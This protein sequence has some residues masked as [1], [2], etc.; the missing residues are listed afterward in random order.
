[1]LTAVVCGAVFASPSAEAV[2]A[3]IRATARPGGPGVLLIVKNYTGDRLNFGVAAEQARS[4]GIDV[5]M[6]VV[7]DDCA[8]PKAKGITGGRGI[9]GTVLV[10]K[11]AG[12]AAAEGA[13]LAEVTATAQATADS[14]RTLG[15]SLSGC[16]LPGQPKAATLGENE[17]ELGLGIHGEPGFVKANVTPA[18]SLVDRVLA[19]ITEPS[20]RTH[21]SLPLRKG[22]KVVLLV[23]NLGS[24]THLELAVVAGR[25]K[26]VL[27]E[28]GVE[29]V[30]V[31]Q[32]P[33]MT[34]LDMHGFSV[35]L[36]KLSSD[37][38]LSRLSLPT[39][40]PAWPKP[41]PPRKY[42]QVLAT[43][44]SVASSTSSAVAAASFTLSPEMGRRIQHS[45]L[46]AGAALLQAEPQLTRWDKA[47]GDGDCGQT[48]AAGAT[49]LIAVAGGGLS[50]QDPVAVTK[51]L[52]EVC[53][54][55]MGGTSGALYT[56]FFRAMQAHLVRNV[57]NSASFSAFDVSN[58]VQAGLL[59]M[60]KYG[61]A[62]PGY[63]TML[64]AMVPAANAFQRALKEG[65]D[66]Q[67]ALA[68]A[69]EAAEAGAKATQ[70]MEALAGR[71][72]YVP[73]QALRNNPDPGAQ[74]A[75]IWIRSVCNS[76]DQKQ[77]KQLTP[78][79]L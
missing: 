35:S 4:E 41:S 8:L 51:A 46:A 22:D 17:I 37:R 72:N 56:I 31:L 40:A 61:G 71:S 48:F 19:H 43:R 6:V 58:A 55:A 66:T 25:A 60:Q 76:W 30:S 24:T 69:A 65:N 5:T 49:Q 53:G 13:S 7:A 64:D 1:M 77:K 63:R 15:V 42:P 26:H 16:T 44:P 33:F 2:L 45:L 20:Q 9:A 68:A 47:V 79:R 54:H 29:V 36:L 73:Q 18:D 59:A 32:G 28:M 27:C 38:D 34:S 39:A 57:S 23:N 12:A 67:A 50:V 75:A 62:K 74:A 78:S 70:G 10:H 21:D 3:A 14:V 11:M 52:A